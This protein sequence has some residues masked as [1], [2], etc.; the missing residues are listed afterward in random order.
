M[1]SLYHKINYKFI[2]HCYLK[3]Y[4]NSL[5]ME[6]DFEY[7]DSEEKK[8]EEKEEKEKEEKKAKKH[9]GDCKMKIEL[10]KYEKGKYLLEFLR[11]GGTFPDY[12]QHFLE[13]KKL[14]SKN[15]NKK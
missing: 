6:V 8:E 7:E 13:I 3:A 9:F 2:N 5:K 4:E 1:K 15:F 14:I 10:F 11:T 12:Y